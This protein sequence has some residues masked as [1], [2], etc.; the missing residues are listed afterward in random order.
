MNEKRKKR[1]QQAEK[2]KQVE[3]LKVEK[4]CIVKKVA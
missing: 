4:N 2:N 3:R 1:I